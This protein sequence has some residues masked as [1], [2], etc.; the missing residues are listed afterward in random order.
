MG[1]GGRED[2]VLS[3]AGDDDE[4]EA[5]KRVARRTGTGGRGRARAEHSSGKGGSDVL[6]PGYVMGRA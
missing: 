3:I 6:A 4:Q 1:R 5:A 2:T